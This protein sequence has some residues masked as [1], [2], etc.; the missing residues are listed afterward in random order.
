VRPRIAL[1]DAVVAGERSEHPS[2][3]RRATPLTQAASEIGA[4]VA[5]HVRHAIT[6]A[7]RS[8]A[9]LHRQTL[10]RTSAERDAVRQKATD[11]VTR[12]ELLEAKVAHTLQELREEA[13]Q[14]A[15][16]MAAAGPDAA[17]SESP[18]AGPFIQALPLS[19]DAVGESEPMGARAVPP[20]DEAE[21]VAAEADRP[22]DEAEPAHAE[23]DRSADEA[24]PVAAEVD[25][26]A[27]EAEP[28]AADGRQPTDDEGATAGPAVEQADEAQ[29]VTG[30]TDPAADQHDTL[31]GPAVGQADEAQPAAGRPDVPETPARTPPQR[32]G[33]LLSRLRRSAPPSCAVCARVSGPDEDV[34][35]WRRERYA[36]LCPDCYAEGWELPERGTIPFRSTH[37][38]EPR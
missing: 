12:I 20:A 36:S 33:G 26:S 38:R 21:P 2:A 16:D 10:A 8:A 22:A 34:L 1:R 27:D 5:E 23:V 15:E 13:M 25:R 14:I 6:E 7:E 19:R 11:V 24:E 4:M 28:V 35:A 17:P 30:Q 31:T 3:P 37:S 9:E 32:R 18:S 29:P